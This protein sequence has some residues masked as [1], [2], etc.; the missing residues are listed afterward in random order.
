M[1]VKRKK[2][3]KNLD[4][5]K[6]IQVKVIG[7]GSRYNKVMIFLKLLPCQQDMYKE[8][9]MLIP[10]QVGFWSGISWKWNHQGG[11]V[12]PVSDP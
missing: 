8:P 11:Y 4:E 7:P 6:P 9:K 5:K 2:E 10:S 3:M 12:L 1:K